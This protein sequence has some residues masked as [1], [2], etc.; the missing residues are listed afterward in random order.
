[1]KN[2]RTKDTGC[3]LVV[4]KMIYAMGY[5]YRLNKRDLP[6]KPDIV[7]GVRKKLIFVNGCF[8]H[9][10]S[11]CSRGKLPESNASFWQKK[12]SGNKKRDREILRK[13]R[14]MGWQSLVVWQCQVRQKNIDKARQRL[15]QF[16]EK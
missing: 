16:M 15:K 1:M 14:N 12:I 8:W 9:G 10:H 4:R 6:G 5:R 3:E 11:R 13:L 2:I 7:F